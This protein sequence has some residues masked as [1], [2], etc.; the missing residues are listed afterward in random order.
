MEAAASRG[1]E[2]RDDIDAAD[3]HKATSP[4]EFTFSAWKQVLLRTWKEAS[5]D[6]LGLIAAGVSFYSF[7][8]LVPLL[9]ATVLT[10]GMVADVATVNG[11]VA[12]IVT[13][14]PGDAGRLISEQLVEVVKSSSDK[15]GTGLLL[16]LA[17]ALFGARNAAGAIVTALNIAY[18]ETERRGFLK[19][20]LLALA[21]TAAAVLTAVFG[22]LGVGAMSL[23]HVA[24][25]EAGPVMKVATQV[26]TYV[27]L[28]AVGATAAALLYRYGPAREKPRWNWLTPGSGLFAVA[29]VLVTIGFGIYASRFGSYGATYGSLSAVVVLLTWMYLSAYA[30]LFGA[31]LNSELEHQTERDTT[32]GPE[33][34][35]GERGAWAADHVAR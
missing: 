5:A 18:E 9:G 30:L 23:V 17:L 29:W 6:S 3:D 12:R 1:T 34:P 11:H 13:L 21:I 31:E 33:R 32:S 20:N 8:A 10:Y 35:L 22:M 19:V 25:P 27:L 28:A 2:A 24:L 4:G 15:K 14:L 26:L 16:A 7:L